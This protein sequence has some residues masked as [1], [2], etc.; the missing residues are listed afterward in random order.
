MAGAQNPLTSNGTSETVDPAVRATLKIGLVL[1]GGRHAAASEDIAAGV[2]LAVA[3]AAAAIGDE[4]IAIIR[5]DTSRNPAD[6]VEAAKRLIAAGAEVLIGPATTRDVRTLR[7]FADS[8]RVPLVV[9]IPGA[10]VLASTTC[11][12]YV[13]HLAPAE[14]QIAAPLATWIGVRTSAKRIYLLAPDELHARQTLAAFKKSFTATGGEVL[15]EEYVAINNPDFAPYLAKLRLMD[16]DSVFAMFTGDSAGTFARQFGELGL[17][18]RVALFGPGVIGGG[19]TSA[20]VASVTG[21]LDY[22]PSLDTPE[23]RGFRDAFARLFARLPTEHAARGYD[24]GRVI[25]DAF[26]ANGGRISDRGIFAAALAQVSFTGP[27]GPIRAEPGR[28][29]APERL[30][31]VREQQGA[32]GTT[33]EVL[34]RVNGNDGADLCGTTRKG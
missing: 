9:P 13:L 5:E 19:A 10:A 22:S 6:T 33:H 18:K 12:P 25:V 2:A 4:A 3:E 32:D 21:A 26:R 27:R 17:A 14:E 30:Y 23:N 11:S 20:K 1:A 29:A 16:A 7:D 15:G 24:A 34:D 8:G 31:I 28:A